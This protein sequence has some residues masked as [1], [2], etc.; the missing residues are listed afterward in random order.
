M[1]EDL[2][3]LAK[4]QE[5][6]RAVGLAVIAGNSLPTVTSI[7]QSQ[8]RAILLD[9]NSRTLP[10]V[11]WVRSLK[12]DPATNPIPIVGFVS[13]VQSDL[14]AAGRAAGCDLVLA[15][16]AFSQQLPDLLRKLG[17]EPFAAPAG[18]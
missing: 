15:R 7:A 18:N 10:V 3:F 16:S 13:H 9:L 4:I 5:T 12:A 8:P 17:G 6:A 2:I 11:K 14:I 1:V